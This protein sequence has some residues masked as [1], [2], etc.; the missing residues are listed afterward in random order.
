SGR[1]PMY[2]E[3]LFSGTLRFV[4]RATSQHGK[5]K[6]PCIYKTEYPL[7]YLMICAPT[8]TRSQGASPVMHATRGQSMPRF[9]MCPSEAFQHPSLAFASPGVLVQG[10]RQVYVKQLVARFPSR[11]LCSRLIS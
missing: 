7:P 5:N 2:L 4:R 8:Y 10:I 1:V 3:S 9:V 6:Q 11:T